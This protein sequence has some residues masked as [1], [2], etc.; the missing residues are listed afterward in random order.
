MSTIKNIKTF[1]NKHYYGLCLF[2]FFIAYMAVIPG[3]CKP[4]IVNDVTYSFYAIDFSVGFCSRVVQGALY[5]LFVKTPSPLTVSIYLTV[6]FIITAGIISYIAEKVILQT[7]SKYRKTAVIIFLFFLVGPSTFAMYLKIFGLI[8]FFWVSATA[9]SLLCLQKKQL[10]FLIV[11]LAVFMVFVYYGAI[12][13][14]VPF[15]AII[16]LYKISAEQ[17]KKE[18]RYLTAVFFAMVII[19]IAFAVYFAAF[20]RSNLLMTMEEF[21]SFMIN[22]GVDA[23]NLYYYDFSFYRYT[24]SFMENNELYLPDADDSVGFGAFVKLILQQLFVAITLKNFSYVTLL[25]SLLILPIVIYIYSFII[26]V[27]KHT[28]KNPVKIFSLICA[29]IFFPF[30]IVAGFCFSTDVVRWI[31]NAFLPFFA[32]FIYVLYKEKEWAWEVVDKDINSIRTTFLI[33]YFLVY[34]LTT[35]LPDLQ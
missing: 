16:L 7:D 1:T 8:D 9:L 2:A 25:V 15:V 4:W 35:F 30:V 21:D 13:C 5:N 24:E 23:G 27:L 29:M 3:E 22:R 17:E 18:K 28:E 32:I 19:A 14:Y 12:L 20:E 10:Y 31:A 26:R 34:S 11:P 6:I 33:P